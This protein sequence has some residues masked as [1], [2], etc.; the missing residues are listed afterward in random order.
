MASRDEYY[1]ALERND[2][3]G[4]RWK[5]ASDNRASLPASDPFKEAVRMSGDHPEPFPVDPNAPKAPPPVMFAPFNRAA[6]DEWN[7]YLSQGAK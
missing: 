4:S 3:V 2:T 7:D 6:I 5:A 1:S